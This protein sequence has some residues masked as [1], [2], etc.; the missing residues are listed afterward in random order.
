MFGKTSRLSVS[1]FQYITGSRH[2]DLILLRLY[3]LIMLNDE[4]SWNIFKI[5]ISTQIDKNN[6]QKKKKC[7]KQ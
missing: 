3:P 2:K 4:T 7:C 6:L 5:Q 1:E